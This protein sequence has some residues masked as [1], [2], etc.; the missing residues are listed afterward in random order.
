MSVFQAGLTDGTR[1]DIQVYPPS[2]EVRPHSR[3]LRL[4]ISIPWI[5]HIL[6][7]RY[8][9][10]SWNQLHRLPEIFSSKLHHLCV[11]VLYR[12]LSMSEKPFELTV[13]I[14]LHHLFRS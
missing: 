12:T 1:P 10:Y 11:G 5:R 8:S 6:P 14:Q 3:L 13:Q 4:I 7:S 9:T 2:L